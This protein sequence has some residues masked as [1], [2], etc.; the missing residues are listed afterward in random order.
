MGISIFI[1]QY[2]LPDSGG[3]RTVDPYTFPE[4]ISLRAAI[5]HNFSKK[6]SKT[7]IMSLK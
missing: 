1:V 5:P 7:I 3:D 6:F 4:K 2:R